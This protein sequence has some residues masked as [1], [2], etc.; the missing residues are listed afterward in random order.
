MSSA[1]RQRPGSGTESYTHGAS[2]NEPCVKIWTDASFK[3]GAM[4]L[5]VMLQT[6]NNEKPSTWAVR[7]QKPGY[8]STQAELHALHFA[9]EQAHA[10]GHTDIVL[11]TDAAMAI[12][13]ISNNTQTYDVMPALHHAMEQ[14]DSVRFQWVPREKN[15]AANAL[16]R[17]ALNLPYSYATGLMLQQCPPLRVSDWSSS[18]QPT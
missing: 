14:L 18:V 4:G 2:F 10:R 3:K 5:G 15:E 12:W 17:M 7:C 9:I 13:H 16:S 6:G 11:Y 8:D 1:I